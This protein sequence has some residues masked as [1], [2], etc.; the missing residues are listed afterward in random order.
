MYVKRESII[1]SIS[2]RSQFHDDGEDSLGP[3]IATLSLGS[4]ATMRFRLKKKYY[5]GSAANNAVL[6]GCEF[7]EERKELKEEHDNGKLKDDE[8]SIRCMKLTNQVTRREAKDLITL[9]LHHG[10]MV[11]MNGSLLQKYYEHSVTSE[12]ILRYALTARHVLEEKLTVEERAKGRYQ[13]TEVQI[14]DGE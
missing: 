4:Q 14:Y 2:D 3:S 7:F 10:D 1:L 9:D 8:Y 13:F 12:G 6:P 5:N 11:V